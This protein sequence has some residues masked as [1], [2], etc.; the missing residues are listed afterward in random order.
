MFFTLWRFP[1]SQ[2]AEL[3][4]GPERWSKPIKVYSRKF[5]PKDPELPER[6]ELKSHAHS[7]TRQPLRIMCNVKRNS[8]VSEANRSDAQRQER[9][10]RKQCIK[11]LRQSSWY[12]LP[13]FYFQLLWSSIA[14]PWWF[15]VYLK[16]NLALTSVHLSLALTRSKTDTKIRDIQSRASKKMWI[17]PWN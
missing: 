13:A 14:L 4:D 8:Q 2:M 3:E 9:P 17:W 15:I 12:Y 5:K 6:V 1:S 10:M 11:P 16:I 7:G